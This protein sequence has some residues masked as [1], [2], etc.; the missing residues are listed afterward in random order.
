MKPIAWLVG[1]LVGGLIGAAAWTVV[2][3]FTDYEL[4]VIAWGI[5][6]L[7]GY[8]VRAVAGERKGAG[9]A[10]AALVAALFSVGVGKV[11]SIAMAVRPGAV[12]E[13]YAVVAL[14]DVV[15]RDFEREGRALEW[16]AGITQEEATEEADYPADVWAEAETRWLA[17]PPAERERYMSDISH[18]WLL[19]REYVISF[20]ADEVVLEYQELGVELEWPPGADREASL[21]RD[22]YP[23]EVWEEAVARWQALTP[24]EQ[25]AIEENEALVVTPAVLWLGAAFYTFSLWDL[26]WLG[27]AGM[28]AW[29]IGSGRDD[30]DEISPPE[31]Q[32]EPPPVPYSSSETPPTGFAPR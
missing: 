20:V 18:L 13:E 17:I 28:S 19:D 5:G 15:V 27:L 26:F 1:G 8:G 2:V 14:A 3:Y 31:E 24:D 25:R 30:D 32:D 22:D 21:S 4:G 12:T 6:V 16:P 11:G 7:S 10:V 29:R 23:L 9:P